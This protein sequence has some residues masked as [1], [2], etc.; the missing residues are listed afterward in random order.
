[1]DPI[2]ANPPTA[3]RVE[4]ELEGTRYSHRIFVTPYAGP[5]HKLNTLGQAFD[6]V[7]SFVT[8]RHD[9]VT[10]AVDKQSVSPLEIYD[11]VKVTISAVIGDVEY[12]EVAYVKTPGGGPLSVFDLVTLGELFS[13]ARERIMVRHANHLG[14][15]VW[16]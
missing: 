3:V 2:A 1:M 14:L 4:I 8:S 13:H 15:D 10:Q 6:G 16:L 7:R 5:E 11:P 12:E 9:F